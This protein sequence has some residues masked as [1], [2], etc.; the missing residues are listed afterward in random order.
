MRRSKLQVGFVG[1]GGMARAHS[2][3]LAARKDVEI[4]AYFDIRP[5]RAERLA[6]QYGARAY[7]SLEQ[8]LDAA[9]LDA[10]WVCLP[11]CAHGAELELAR[12]GIPFFVEKPINLYLEQAKQIAAAVEAK[13]LITSAGYM[14][15]YRRGVETVRK[16]LADDPAIL[17]L[18]G[19]IGGTPGPDPGEGIMSWWV[20]KAQSGGQFHEQVT[21]TVDV[22]RY[23]CGDAVEVC[24]FGARGFNRGVAQS[25]DIEDAAAVSVK[26]ASGAVANLWASCSANAGGGGV[27][28]SVYARELTALFTGWEQSVRL[29][30]VGKDTVEIKG[31]GDVFAIEDDVFLK[32]VRSGDSSAIRSTY[33]DALG[34]IAITQ[35]GRAHV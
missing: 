32:A 3:P 23:L 20:Q 15:R 18:G 10:A 28:L 26:F 11:P 8:M 7:G 29:M 25:Y 12:R 6:Q 30:R 31:E 16:L 2:A 1:S 33:S 17:A 34:T 22:A 5:E 19:W 27:S 24:A 9:D 13:G 14:T 35:I 4:A 21:H